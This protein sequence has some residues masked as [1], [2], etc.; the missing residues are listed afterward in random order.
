[1]KPFG[2]FLNGCGYNEG[3]DIWEAVLLQYF[4]DEKKIKTLYLFSSPS[5]SHNEQSTLPVTKNLFSETSIIAH[6][7]L[8]ELREISPE[9]LE[10][11]I[12]PGGEGILKKFTQLNLK[13]PI[14]KIDPELKKF[15]RETYRR[16]IV[17]A[18]CGLSCLVIAY[19]LIDIVT[20]PLI[21]T[22]GNDPGLSNQLEKL[23]VNHVI[24]KPYEA[25]IDAENRV[26]TTPGS[27]MRANLGDLGTGLKNLIDG[28]LE[29]TK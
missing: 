6:G 14:L 8:K 1:M 29:L 18:G 17:I 3:T 10:A 11:L 12:L 28:I 20:S 9:S 7:G 21:L 15:I 27:K 2:I 16:K 26:V 22:T 19:S 13:N 23:G 25:V 24:T 4:L 5:F